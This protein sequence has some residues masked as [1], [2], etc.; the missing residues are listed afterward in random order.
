MFM[1]TKRELALSANVSFEVKITSLTG[2]SIVTTTWNERENI[3]KLIPPHKKH[4]ST[5]STRDLRLS[6]KNKAE[7]GFSQKRRE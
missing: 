7:A 5:G 6:A 2:V 4:V 3:E 1:C